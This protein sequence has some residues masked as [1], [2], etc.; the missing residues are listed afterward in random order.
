MTAT[1]EGVTKTTA[2]VTMGLLQVERVCVDDRQSKTL[3]YHRRRVARWLGG[4]EHFL[5]NQN[6]LQILT[7]MFNSSLTPGTPL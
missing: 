3:E 4:Y 6:R 2:A 7:L 5:F 1:V